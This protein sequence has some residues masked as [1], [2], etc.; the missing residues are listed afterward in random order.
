LSPGTDRYAS[1]RLEVNY[2]AARRALCAVC[3]RRAQLGR[4]LL[5]GGNELRVVLAVPRSDRAPG[6]GA[7]GHLGREGR[8]DADGVANPEDGP[9]RPS[10]G[11]HGPEAVNRLS[12]KSG[13][14][15]HW[16]AD[17][18]PAAWGKTL[19][20]PAS[21]PPGASSQLSVLRFR[22]APHRR[23]FL[24]GGTEASGFSA[25]FASAWLFRR[26]VDA[27]E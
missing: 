8:A 14:I 16:A 11:R 1:L 23:R 22:R 20:L 18:W 10:A 26:A 24:A 6:G 27:E 12:G 7:G 21:E 4:V 5:P 19:V 2:I 13:D 17:A 15:P 9:H 25:P 3:R